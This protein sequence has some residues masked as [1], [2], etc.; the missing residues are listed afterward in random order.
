MKLSDI[1][2]ATYGKGQAPNPGQLKAIRGIKGPML[3][4]AGPGSGKTK[5]LITRALN[6][7]IVRK[8]KPENI[9][10]CTFTEK[11]AR[12]LRDRLNAG[13]NKCNAEKIDIHEMTIGTIHSVCQKIID[14]YPNEAGIGVLSKRIGLGRGYSVLDDLRRMFFLMDNFDD[15]FSAYTDS[16]GRYMGLWKG[17]WDTIKRCQEVFDKITEQNIELKDLRNSSDPQIKLIGKP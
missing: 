5:T 15:I 1:V 4:V 8:I 3:L 12:Q 14:E 16:D 13:L 9:L 7:L 2:K 11:A 10:L 6:L 17:F